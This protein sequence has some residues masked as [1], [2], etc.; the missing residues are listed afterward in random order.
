MA[1]RLPP[2]RLLRLR[3]CGQL[4]PFLTRDHAQQAGAQSGVLRHVMSSRATEIRGNKAS[5]TGDTRHCVEDDPWTVGV[6]IEFAGPR[7]HD[8][9]CSGAGPQRFHDPQSVFGVPGPAVALHH[10]TIPVRERDEVGAVVNP[11]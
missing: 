10:D 7:N 3:E 9:R 6:E 1:R 11:P 2:L 5:G 8:A 4:E